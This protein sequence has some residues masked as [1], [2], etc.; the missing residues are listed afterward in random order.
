M[1]NPLHRIWT[2]RWWLRVTIVAGFCGGILVWIG[3]R[4]SA[5]RAAIDAILTFEADVYAQY[6]EHEY[7]PA[8]WLP[9][10]DPTAL[11]PTFSMIYSVWNDDPPPPVIAWAAP[12][13]GD[14]FGKRVTEIYISDDQFTDADV[15]LLLAFPDLKLL[16][17][18]ETGITDSGLAKLTALEQLVSLNVSWTRVSGKS[19]RL[20]AN[21][22][23]LK[24]LNID[25][26]I[27]DAQVA[28][29][30]RSRLPECQVV[31]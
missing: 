5:Q 14:D 16:D 28:D 22:K 10:D 1:R 4:A 26:T 31:P 3:W 7:A 30:L 20:L 24:E 18:A 25:E 12:L 8:Y 19:T 13:L 27:D 17:I 23:N 21:L 9:P 15:D 2:N 11:A 29:D 6:G